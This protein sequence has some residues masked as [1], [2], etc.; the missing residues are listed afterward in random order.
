MREMFT[1]RLSPGYHLRVHVNSNDRLRGFREDRRPVSG[2]A[3]DLDHV[4]SAKELLKSSLFRNAE[5]F[6]VV[7]QISRA[8]V[9]FRRARRVVSGRFFGRRI[10]GMRLH[11][12]DPW[13]EFPCRG[14]FTPDFSTRAIDST[15][16]DFPEK[17]Q[18][19]DRKGRAVFLSMIC[20][21]APVILLKA[22]YL[23]ER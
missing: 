15:R 23:F 7:S 17:K 18:R 13:S 6:S 8:E 14:S 2:P 16:A 20:D 9:V 12:E 11:M 10:A 1:P 19:F 21:P 5:S 3:R 4:V 22:F